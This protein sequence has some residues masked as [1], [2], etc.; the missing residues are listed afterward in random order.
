MMLGQFDIH[1]VN[2]LDVLSIAL[3][4]GAAALVLARGRGAPWAVRAAAGLGLLALARFG[5]ILALQWLLW[6]RGT[7][8]V[9]KSRLYSYVQAGLWLVGTAGLALLVVAVLSQ[10]REP[11]ARAAAS[12]YSAVQP[13]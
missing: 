7:G 9:E 6:S 13:E 5:G 8:I 12:P 1:G 10:R 4:V 3:F 11:A 2:V